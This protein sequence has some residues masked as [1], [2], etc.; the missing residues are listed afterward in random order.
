MENDKQQL[1]DQLEA[2]ETEIIELKKQNAILQEM[3]AKLNLLHFGTKSEKITVEDKKQ[4]SLFNEAEDNAFDQNNE[5]QQEAVIETIEIGPFKKRVKKVGRKPLSEDLPREIIVYDIPEEDKICPCGKDK[6]CIGYDVSERAK[7]IPSKI[8]VIQERKKKYACANC[9]GTTAD[10]KGIQ[11]AKGAKHLIPG[12]I[13]D[14]S[15]LAWS[16]NEK[17]E[18][19][20]PFYRQ[21]KRLTNIG[22]PITR[23][24]LSNLTIKSATACKPIYELLE[25]EIKSSSIINADETRIQVLNE[26]NRQATDKSWM[27]VFLRGDPDKRCVIFQYDESRSHQVPYDFLD[28]YTGWL[29]TDDYSA[30]HTALKKIN[31]DIKHV[32]CW[33]HARRKFFQYWESTKK[34][35]EE[36][37]KIL[38][39][40]KDLFKLESLRETFSIEEF[41]TERQKQSDP[42]LTKLKKKLMTIYSQVPPSLGFG[43][44]IKYT[45]SNWEQL[46][47]YLEN[48]NLTPSNNCA[49]NAIRPFVIGRKNWLF[50]GSP[51]GAESSAI[52]YSLVESAKMNNLIV[53]DYLYYIFRKIPYCQDKSDYVKL[54][55]YNL[56]SEEIKI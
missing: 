19:A 43:K 30:Y 50:A 35:D 51:K 31:G 11:T 17:F 41:Q 12:S 47:L 16:I 49:E 13:A 21:S 46:V 22:I 37:K 4:G 40:I 44:A 20:L 14:E 3:V 38:D 10:E 1:K 24:T 36:A 53:Y 52:L 7:I 28:Q 39:L 48:P 55:P 56:T 8:V 25:N 18:F 15:L 23:A 9:E 5:D 26:P 33:A 29:Q 6:I 45:L 27:W 32:L 34:K 54:L 2:K 42:I